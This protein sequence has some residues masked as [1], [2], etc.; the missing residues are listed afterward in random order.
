M[1]VG[2]DPDHLVA[3]TRG[4]HRVQIRDGIFEMTT[5]HVKTARVAGLPVRD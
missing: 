3:V 5:A 2:Q 1:S 4:L